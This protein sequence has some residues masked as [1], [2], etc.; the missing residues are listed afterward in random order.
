[1]GIFNYS[2]DYKKIVLIALSRIKKAK[3]V[4]EAFDGIFKMFDE[5][6]KCFFGVTG[7]K[8]VFYCAL[9][10]VRNCFAST[11][12]SPVKKGKE[13]EAI[14]KINAIISDSIYDYEKHI[15]IALKIA[16]N[17][18]GKT[19]NKG[20]SEY[21][22]GVNFKPAN[23]FGSS[24]SKKNLQNG[25]FLEFGGKTYK[26][27]AVKYNE[28]KLDEYI[29]VGSPSPFNVGRAS[30]KQSEKIIFEY[31]R[32]A[33]NEQL[34]IDP[35]KKVSLCFYGHCMVGT[36]AVKVAKALSSD[37]EI[38]HKVTIKLIVGDPFSGPT[39]SKTGTNVKTDL[40]PNN[41]PNS[42]VKNAI[43]STIFY[44][45][46]G[47]FFKS[48]GISGIFNKKINFVPQMI[49]G[50]TRIIISSG[51]HNDFNSFEYFQKFISDEG[52]DLPEP[53]IYLLSGTYKVVYEPINKSN[54]EATVKK[55]YDFTGGND[56]ERIKI[57]TNIIAIYLKMKPDELLK[58]LPDYKSQMESVLNKI[59]KSLT[60]KGAFSYVE[61]LF[62]P[63]GF[64]FG[65]L[66]ENG[67]FYKTVVEAKSYVVGAINNK[68]NVALYVLAKEKNLADQDYE[69]K[70][71][72]ALIKRIEKWY[73]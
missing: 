36:E 3:T 46:G 68:K 33:I 63:S 1:M 23:T 26:H 65:F 40:E 52:E 67:T 66:N 51:H 53:G 56:K 4:H 45:M 73:S 10:E 22:I 58:S 8:S 37:S 43:E 49:T 29:I 11:N 60:L 6:N 38:G 24:L 16:I 13:K 47:G 31:L 2:P 50:A 34:E 55:I 62:K 69:K 59:E 7:Q 30:V 14:D 32:Y 70:L 28:P 64:L 18:F 25:K 48:D 57:L 39:A 44:Q 27:I 41:V 21:K 61:D 5:K 17:R 71:Y 12:K 20:K 15:A 54:I 19:G 35:E 72:T 42:N 9:K